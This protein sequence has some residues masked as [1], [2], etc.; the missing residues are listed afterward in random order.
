MSCNHTCWLFQGN[1]RPRMTCTTISK[2]YW[3]TRISSSLKTIIEIQIKIILRIKSIG[4][5]FQKHS[6]SHV[7]GGCYSGGL[8]KKS[9]TLSKNVWNFGFQGAGT[10]SIVVVFQRWSTCKCKTVWIIYTSLTIYNR[11]TE[12]LPYH[13]MHMFEVTIF[14]VPFYH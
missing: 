9:G 11:K 2:Q 14:Y 1:E 13:W 5:T 6:L 7:Q 4:H 8:T 12:F 10:S 3:S